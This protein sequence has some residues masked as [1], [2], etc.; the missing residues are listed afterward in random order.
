MVHWQCGH[1]AAPR[2]RR[3]LEPPPDVYDRH[4][5][6]QDAQAWGD[7]QRRTAA[8]TRR[9][10]GRRKRQGGAERVGRVPADAD[11]CRVRR[12]R[13]HGAAL[14]AHRGAGVRPSPAPGRAR[15]RRRLRS[16]ARGRQ[17]PARPRQDR[18]CGAPGGDA[19][20]RGAGPAGAHCLRDPRLHP[21][22]LRQPLRPGQPPQVRGLRDIVQQ[23]GLVGGPYGVPDRI[24][25]VNS[26][27][28]QRAASCR[29]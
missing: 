22:P 1:Q 14:R 13:A 4:H 19:H 5:H 6:A 28:W 17:D 12:H 11:G 7:G 3:N 29:P 2:T 9:R 18:R 10:L 15:V 27:S 25:R 23:V 26:A 21:G 20:R 8:G 24:A 16:H